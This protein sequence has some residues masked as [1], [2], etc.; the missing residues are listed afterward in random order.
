MDK[1]RLILLITIAVVINGCGGGAD[2]GGSPEVNIAPFVNAGPD[3]EVD[4][5]TF[6]LLDGDASDSD[7]AIS[8]T[9]WT[10]LSGTEVTLLDSG[11]LTPTFTSPMID[12]DQTLSFQL[13][14]I[15]NLGGTSTD[16]VLINVWT[17][18]DLLDTK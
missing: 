13:T 8:S 17:S 6:V 9:L 14:V 15:D 1:I 18:Q 4:E 5:Q 3:L 10:Q 7:G 12:D 11:T 2:L 16:T